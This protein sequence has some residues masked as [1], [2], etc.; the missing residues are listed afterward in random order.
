MSNSTSK[1]IRWRGALAILALAVIAII[2]TWNVESSRQDRILRTGLTL[3]VSGFLLFL[4]AILFSRFSG[5]LRLA[6]FAGGAATIALAVYKLEIT[7]VT[8][9]LLPIVRLRG[10]KTETTAVSTASATNR[11]VA[12]ASFPQFLGPTRD[13][14]IRNVILDTNW[15]SKPPELLWRRPMGGAWSGFAIVDGIAITQEQRDGQELVT[16]LNLA[17]GKQVWSHADSTRYFTTLGGEGPRA[18]PTVHADRV[19]TLGGNGILNCLDLKNGKPFWS[20][21]LVKEHS[22]KTPEWGFAG[23]P[24]VHDGKVI[25]NAGGKPGRSVV[26]YDATTGQLAWTSGEDSA[27]Y[28]SPVFL[29]LAGVPQI[30]VFNH[31]QVQAHNSQTGAILW[32]H[33][34]PA[35]HPHVTIPIPVSTNKLLVSSGYGYG[36]EL[37]EI[38]PT[39]AT[40]VW[41]SNRLKS[42]FANLIFHQNFVYGLDDGI[43]ACMDPATGERK[44]H[45]SRQGHGQMLLVGDLILLM[46]ESGAVLLIEPSPQEEQI[47]AR[48][49]ALNNK[50]W[51]P[52]ALAGDILIVRNNLEAACFKLP[53]KAK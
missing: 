47:V 11:I 9:D 3:I 41:K 15:T 51:N 14:V 26:A 4:W 20:K 37:L 28:S 30:V 39:N 17:D 12:K 34:W 8:G 43:L 49:E 24:L 6:I 50:T 19:Y 1:P 46:A 38:S 36:S 42:K 13:G 21:D 32:E 25:V 33:P 27:G 5:R 48:F 44:W 7:G 31:K 35:T 18:T 16:A 23:S 2:V 53:L 40:R 10:K 29:T 22:T 52:P 45:G